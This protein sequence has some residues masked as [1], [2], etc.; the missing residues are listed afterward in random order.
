MKIEDIEKAIKE[1]GSKD[2]MPRLNKKVE[3]EGEE[4]IS[5]P[6]KSR[7]WEDKKPGLYIP[8]TNEIFIYEKSKPKGR[9]L[10][11]K[12]GGKVSS[13]SARADGI[14]QRGKTRGRMI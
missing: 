1:E 11:L 6:M 7:D 9:S 3:I 2:K 12:K 5:S 14:A 8:E 4:V 13:A 10:P